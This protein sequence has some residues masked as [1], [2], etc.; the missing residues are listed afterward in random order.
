MDI[1]QYPISFP[2]GATSAPYSAVHPHLGD[3]HAAPI[4]TSVVVASTEIGK[5]GTTGLSSGPHAHIAEWDVGQLPDGIYVP[6]YNHTYF[7]PRGALDT[8]G[9]VIEVS[10]QDVGEA[11]KYVRWRGDDGRVREVFHLSEVLIK[12]GDRIGDDM[13]SAQLVQ[14]AFQV[15]F[16][17]PATD[18]EIT[19]NTK[20]SPEEVLTNVLANNLEF[21][22]KAAN[23]DDLAKEYAAFK[24]AASQDG[25]VLDKGKYIVQ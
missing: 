21:R 4:G 20:M 5:V 17:R 11:G 23:Y 18:N 19:D 3:D 25:K 2:Y 10:Y 24:K 8:P 15:A 13:A 22:S 9:V 14:L 7:K 1:S 6:A 12:V 16:N